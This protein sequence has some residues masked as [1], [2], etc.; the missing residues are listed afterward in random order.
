MVTLALS[1]TMPLLCWMRDL[2]P[3]I[4]KPEAKILMKFYNSDRLYRKVGDEKSII[5]KRQIEDQSVELESTSSIGE[6]I[7]G[8]IN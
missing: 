4:P 2:G 1:H 3:R 8:I 7:K 5:F 6:E